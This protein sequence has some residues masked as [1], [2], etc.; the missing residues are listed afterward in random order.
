MYGAQTPLQTSGNTTMVGRKRVKR[1]R[2]AGGKG[3][4]SLA[5]PIRARVVHKVSR[6]ESTA[7]PPKITFPHPTNIYVRERLFNLLDRTRQDHRV[8]WVSA[9]GGAG[10]TSLAASYLGAHKLPVL[11]YQVDQG[12]GDIASFFYYMGLAA[13]QAAPRYKHPL[14]VLTPEYLG[15]IP[16][17]TRNFFRELY[18]RLRKNSVLVLDNYQD[19]P[20]DSL[21][22]DVLHIAMSEAPEGMNLFVLSRI[23]PPAVLARLRLC[24]HAACLDWGK[25]QLTREETAGLV[26]LRT[27]HDLPDPKVIDTL[28]ARTEGW[29]A[30]VVLMLEESRSGETLDIAKLPAGQKLLFDYFAGEILSRS[31]PAVRDFLLKTALFPKVTVAAAQALTGIDNA[32][33]I[34]DDLTRRNYFTVRNASQAQDS[35][36]YH[37]MFR[38]F[39]RAQ[40]QALH[41]PAALDAL[42]R[43]A[44]R[45]LVQ[46][47]EVEEA[48]A[49]FQQSQSWA[50]LATLICANTP[51]LIAQGRY[52]TVQA[53]IAPLPEPL[54]EQEPWILLWHGAAWQPFDLP[55]ARVLYERAYARFKAND[56]MA[57]LW[58]SWSGIVETYIFEWARFAP[59]DHW[60]AEFYALMAQDKTPPTPELMGRA[61]VG[62]FTALMYRQPG[63]A[64]LPKWVAQLEAMLHQRLDPVAMTTIGMQLLTYYSF[65]TG[66][67]AR[68]HD[69]FALVAPVAGRSKLPPLAAIAWH[70][71]Q[72]IHGWMTAENDRCVAAA[73]RGLEIARDTGVHLFDVMLR[74]Q[75]TSGLVTAGRLEEAARALDQARNALIPTRLM[76]A[77]Y[78]QLMLANLSFGAESARQARVHG[79]QC[80][81]LAREAGCPWAIGQALGWAIW[82]SVRAG[83]NPAAEEHLREAKAIVQASASKLTA[84]VV[85]YGEWYMY[86]CSTKGDPRQTLTALRE[87][88]ALARE[89]GVV[90]WLA[91]PYP[92]TAQFCAR[93]LAHDIETDYVRALVK[94]RGLLPPANEVVPDSWPFPIKLHTLGHFTVTVRDEPLP[95]SGKLARKPL[96]LLKLLVS[97]G[98]R[99]MSTELAIETL[100]PEQDMERSYQS[101]SM[102]LHRLRKLLGMDESILSQDGRVVLNDRHV[103]VDAWALERSLEPQGAEGDAR[104]N[105]AVAL[106]EG[107]FL[108]EAATEPWAL[109]YGERLYGKYLRAVLKLGQSRQTQGAFEHAIELY[110]NALEHDGLQESLHQRLLVCYCETGRYADGLRAYERCRNRL[111]E[112]LGVIPSAQTEALRA[113]LLKGNSE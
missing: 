3:V 18:R 38:E 37:P 65:W 12:D 2:P 80:L 25:I 73:R 55:R 110:Q 64:D 10:K 57:G 52:Q 4:K 85:R 66:D 83:D 89:L 109:V 8:I 67:M 71:S 82:T 30:G 88:W 33:D 113:R 98:P 103:W 13:K 68:A 108:G 41:S 49:L 32:Q 81:Y 105:H 90:N 15:D 11:W 50:E 78:V 104:L 21:L 92:A 28:H 76:D 51:A 48:A 61:V 43:E 34:L 5:K 86:S 7:I 74:I 23:E 63:H 101:Y 69:L 106:Y 1:S 62:I 17:F 20:E 53:W 60:I 31:D 26:R 42:R 47:G 94:K 102:A 22:H 6:A 107:A 19:V 99:G 79:E 24:D 72:A 91:W 56:D 93:A 58:L 112:A 75:E 87:T 100:W 27:G 29:A 9:P 35:Y 36:E 16:T 59:L 84:F 77:S 40:A 70:V 44:A 45:I 97:A 14:P 54:Y 96:D 46:A 39:L 95:S 111:Q